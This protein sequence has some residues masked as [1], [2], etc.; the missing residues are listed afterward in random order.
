MRRVRRRRDAG[1][2]AEL[3]TRRAGALA[4]LTLSFA[5]RVSRRT[6]TAFSASGK[7]QR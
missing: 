7:K 3:K 1:A 2:R 6:F 5:V 4:S